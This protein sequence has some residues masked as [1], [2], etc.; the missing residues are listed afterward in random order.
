MVMGDID[1]GLYKTLDSRFRGNDDSMLS[2]ERRFNAFAGTTIAAFTG[3]T[4]PL[5]PQP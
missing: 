1:F 2:R 4:A 3:T 5:L